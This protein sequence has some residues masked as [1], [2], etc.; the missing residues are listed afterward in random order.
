MDLWAHLWGF[1]A[2]GGAGMCAA[3]FLERPD[4]A[5]VQLR[6]GVV[7]AATVVLCWIAALA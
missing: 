4:N 1:V 5:G 2:G 6:I 7:A 3:L